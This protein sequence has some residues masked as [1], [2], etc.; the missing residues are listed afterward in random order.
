[1]DIEIKQKNQLLKKYGWIAAIGV[2]LIIAIVYAIISAGTT[3]HKT[4]INAITIGEVSRGLFNDN[5]R[6]T[7]KVETGTSVQ[8]SAL[9]TG[10]VESRFFEEGAIVN[11]GDIILTLRNPN[12]RQQIL[13]SEAQLAEKQNMLRDTEIAMEKDR[14]QIKQDLLVARTDLNRKRRVAQQQDELYKEKLTSRE[15]YLIAQEDFKL[16]E[17][18][19][20][21][22]LNRQRQD[23]LYRGVQLNMMRESL[24]NMQEN[25]LLVRQ[26]AD[27]LNIRASHTGQLGSLNAELGQNIAA[28]TQVGQ[29]N[30]LDNYKISVNIDEHYIDRVS[31]GLR[32]IARRQNREFDLTLS[33]VY[34]EVTN[35][36]FRADLSIENETPDNLRVGQTYSIDLILGEPAEAVLV[37]RGSFFQ[38]TGGRYIYVLSPDG[39]TATRR[40]IRL[41]RQNPQ[42]YEVVE[43]LNPGERV[44]TSSYQNFGNAQK[45]II[46]N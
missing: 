6:L 39:K 9:E 1:M 27:N 35:G 31:T 33:K 5:I 37:P 15:E 18:N 7:G 8:I 41:G 20:Q 44:I 45:I 25:F 4:D 46:N 10:I 29:I 28:G 17:E 19:Y 13:D 16:A 22:L 38:S 2:V 42:F 34:P 26:R 40:D 14:L 12:L 11:A 36:T 23:S 32:A 24:R 30:I 21:L 3:S 43:G